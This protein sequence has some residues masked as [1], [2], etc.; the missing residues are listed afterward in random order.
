MNNRHVRITSILVLFL[1]STVSL[2]A[3]PEDLEDFNV[4]TMLEGVVRDFRD[5]GIG[6]SIR[7]NELVE[8]SFNDLV[9]GSIFVDKD[10]IAKKVVNI[11]DSPDGL[12]IETRQ[13]DIYEVFQYIDIPETVVDVLAPGNDICMD[14]PENCYTTRNPDTR[15]VT[16]TVNVSPMKGLS[17]TGSSTIYTFSVYPA[18]KLPYIKKKGWPWKWKRKKG[19]AKGTFKYKINSS[20]TLSGSMS[21][22]FSKRVFVPGVSIGISSSAFT[23]GG[24]VYI[25]VRGGASLS[26]EQSATYYM[27]GKNWVKCSLKGLGLLC[28]PTKFRKGTSYYYYKFQMNSPQI[29]GKLDGKMGVHA[30]V[31]VKGFGFELLD[32]N[33]GTGLAADVNTTFEVASGNYLGYKNYSTGSIPGEGW[34][35]SQGSPYSAFSRSGHASFRIYTEITASLFDGDFEARLYNKNYN[36]FKY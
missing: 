26:I 36:L 20:L 2:S 27:N 31:V 15:A 13:P 18:I 5:N 21:K 29:V 33:G 23:V 25:W 3:I 32:I 16:L 10:G 9:V 11:I 34:Y 19:Y 30:G 28:Y 14:I 4:I 17:V 35:C 8:D 24:G 6:F 1:L 7:N 22:S 12:I